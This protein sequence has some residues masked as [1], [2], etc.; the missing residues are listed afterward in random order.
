MK[1][2]V[3][4]F[5]F[6]KEKSQVLLIE[7]RRPEWQKYKYNGIGGL[8][9]NDETLRQAM[10]RECKEESGLDIKEWQYVA[11]VNCPNITLHYFKSFID[12]E[13]MHQFQSCTDE[14]IIMCHLYNYSKNYFL[15]RMV[16]P[17]SWLLLAAVDDC[18]SDFEIDYKVD[19]HEKN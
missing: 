18:V 1:E 7:K 14:A 12:L 2:Y 9:E 6:D 5:V 16:Q 17:S 10:I 4:G 3:V 13:H 19:G 11:M 8:V 15:T